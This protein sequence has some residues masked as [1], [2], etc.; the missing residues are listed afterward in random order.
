[1]GGPSLK[2]WPECKETLLQRSVAE[3]ELYDAVLED[4]EQERR[5]DWMLEMLP[6]RPAHVLNSVK[7]SELSENEI[8][9]L[10]ESADEPLRDLSGQD[11]IAVLDA[12][13]PLLGLPGM[14]YAL[15]NYTAALGRLLMSGDETLASAGIRLLRGHPEHLA[16]PERACGLVS[17]LMK[18]LVGIGDKHQPA[19]VH[20][21]LDLRERLT[22][23][24]L[25]SLIGMFFDIAT[26]DA[27]PG[28]V[29]HALRSLAVLEVTYG[30]RSANFVHVQ[31]RYK[32]L[33]DETMRAA[34]REGLAQLRP[35]PL[36]RKK[37][38]KDFWAWQKGLA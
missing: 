13:A 23:E 2:D 9:C 22:R 16:D 4:T 12:I 38:A 15:G 20:A 7:A 3:T 26:N 36:P 1:M 17:E 25:D 21:I 14:D 34:I 24:E 28:A 6:K 18:W 29:E 8:V 11:L 10:S 30:D 19:T 27:R 37:E 32:S 5:F 35:S 31:T 33:E